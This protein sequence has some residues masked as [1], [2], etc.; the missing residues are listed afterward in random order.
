MNKQVNYT[1][2]G[3]FV[4]VFIAILVWFVVWMSAVIGSE[5]YINYKI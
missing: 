3:A 1:W 5:K 4:I 2:V